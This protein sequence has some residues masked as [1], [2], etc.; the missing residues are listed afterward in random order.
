MSGDKLFIIIL[1]KSIWTFFI[2]RK[3]QKGLGRFLGEST[4]KVFSGIFDEK[5]PINA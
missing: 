2:T 4:L 3:S 1:S 5:Q